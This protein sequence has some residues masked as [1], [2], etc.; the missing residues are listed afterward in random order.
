MSGKDAKNTHM[1][2]CTVQHD[3]PS[4]GDLDKIGLT[5]NMTCLFIEHCPLCAAVPFINLVSEKH[6]CLVDVRVSVYLHAWV[7]LRS[8][9][10]A[11]RAFEGL[12]V[13]T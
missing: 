8:A 3:T 4:F 5:Q 7:V 9:S 12:F 1:Q 11:Q 6:A 2:M 13:Q 10:E